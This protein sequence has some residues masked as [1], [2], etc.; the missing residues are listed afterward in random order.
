MDFTNSSDQLLFQKTVRD[1]LEGAV[2]L[3]EFR[4]HLDRQAERVARGEPPFDSLAEVMDIEVDGA[5]VM[6]AIPAEGPCTVIANHPFGG[7]DALAVGVLATRARDDVKI[8]ANVEAMRLPGCCDHL[9][10]LEILGSEGSERANLRMLRQAIRHLS[11][12]GVLVNA[13][14]SFEGPRTRERFAAVSSAPGEG[15]IFTQGQDG[16][17]AWL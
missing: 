8:L 6:E 4:R 11:D 10:P 1:F 5:G 9:F 16:R 15:L 13:G 3:P 12:G 14:M 7:P 2:G 17:T